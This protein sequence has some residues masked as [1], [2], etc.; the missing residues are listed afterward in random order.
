[1]DNIPAV[2]D[3]PP[4]INTAEF[5]KITIFN[6][7]EPVVATSIVASTTYSILTVGTTDFTLIGASDNNVG[8]TFVATG[9]GTG[10][11]TANDVTIATFSSAYRDFTIDGDNYNALGGL[12]GVGA[13]QK[14]LR[15]T[16]ADTSVIL[17]GIDGTNIA[18]VLG[19][20]IRG[21]KLEITRGFFDDTGGLTSTAKRFTGIITSYNITEERIDTSDVFTV[22]VNASSYK[23][24]LANRKAGRRTNP[25]SWEFFDPLDSSMVNVYSI[26]SQTFDFGKKVT[27]TSGGGGGGGCFVAGTQIAMYDDTL[28]S[29]EDIHAGDPIWGYDLETKTK[30]KNTVIKTKRIEVTELVDIVH[31]TKTLTTTRDHPIFVIGK[32]WASLDPDQTLVIHG[33][34]AVKYELDDAVLTLDGTAEQVTSITLRDVAPTSVYNLSSVTPSHNFYAN[35]VL[36]HNKRDDRDNRNVQQR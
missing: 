16:S 32:G 36:V 18:T 5:V 6:E 22:A 27:A 34:E 9:P 33:I 29:I 2:A 15:V 13:Q 7:Y 25:T 30:V 24:V 31:G 28:K 26:A 1:M 3:S 4:Q 21:S 14:D 11:G 19:T 17:S 35:N 23:T 10:T 20:K 12:L 8:T